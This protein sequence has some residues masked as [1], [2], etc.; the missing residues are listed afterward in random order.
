MKSK[1]RFRFLNVALHVTFKSVG[2]VGRSFLHGTQLLKQT[3]NWAGVAD[4]R[5]GI[6]K[7]C[8]LSLFIITA[9]ELRA[10]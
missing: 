9:K 8:F 1:A 7:K 5:P 6:K 3:L 10:L 2:S 4:A